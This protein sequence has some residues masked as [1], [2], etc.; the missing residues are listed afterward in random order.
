MA[1]QASYWPLVGFVVIIL[2]AAGGAAG[3]VAY[4]NPVHAPSHVPTVQ[5]GD[6]VTVEY[7]G[8]L[9]SGPQNG[10][11]FGT[12]LLSVA[13]NNVTYPKALTFAFGNA[14][15]YAW[16]PLHVGYDVPSGGYV[17]NNYTFDSVITGFWSGILGMAGNTTRTVFIPVNEGYG[18][19]DAACFET[20]SLVFS[21]PLTE[22]LTRTSFTADYPGVTI[23][24]GVTFTDPLYGWTDQIYSVNGSW[25]TYVN[26]PTKGQT[27]SPFGLPYYVSGLTSQSITLTSSLSATQAGKVLGKLPGNSTVC[28]SSTFIVSSINWA[29]GTF[30]W[31]FN[32]ELQGQNL[33]FVITVLDIFPA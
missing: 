25:V 6:N 2:V 13:K 18:P 28:D 23:Q 26:L 24:Q 7:T 31:N 11:V 4:I 19:A 5:Y 30:A 17:I 33:R 8:Y 14:S 1:R 20:E 12:S 32:S 29:T 15:D 9:A 22:N 16:F 21:V 27:S 10:T 3:V